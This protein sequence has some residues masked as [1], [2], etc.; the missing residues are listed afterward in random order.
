[1][2]VVTILARLIAPVATTTS[3]IFSSGG[4]ELVAVLRSQLS[5]LGQF[6][7]GSEDIFLHC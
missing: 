1:M 5:V 2:L 6:Q 3:I 4:M 7:D